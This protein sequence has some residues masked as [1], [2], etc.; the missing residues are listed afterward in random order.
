MK[1]TLHY[2]FALFIAIT[3]CI[4]IG[5]ANYA[6]YQPASN[7]QFPDEQ[8]AIF[9]LS[10]TLCH[11]TPPSENI[12]AGTGSLPVVAAK[13][14]LKTNNALIKAIQTTYIAQLFQYTLF[15]KKF[16]IKIR[17]KQTLFPFHHFW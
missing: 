10:T 7:I 11:H 1:T 14:H 13:N 2:L 15:F 6:L 8:N 3:Y 12:A 9:Q 17:K 5:G 4:A 16:L